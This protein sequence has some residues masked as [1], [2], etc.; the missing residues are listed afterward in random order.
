MLEGKNILLNH[1]G[2][3]VKHGFFTTRYVEAENTKK[4]ELA[5]IALVKNDSSFS[6]AIQ[7][8]SSSEPIIY[9]EELNEIESFKDINTPGTGYSFYR[10]TKPWW[11]F[12][13]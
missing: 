6:K 1:E 11:K 9:L 8:D 13:N 3:L 5:A 7:N 12:W 2:N 10:D 4:A